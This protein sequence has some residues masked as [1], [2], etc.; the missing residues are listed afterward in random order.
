MVGDIRVLSP[1]YSAYDALD[2]DYNPASGQS[3]LVTHGGGAASWEDAGVT[4]LPNGAPYDNG[5]ILTNTTDV[6]PLRANPANSDGNFNPRV[7]AST[8]EKK[9]LMVTSSVFAATHGQFAATGAAGPV[10]GPVIANPVSRPLMSLDVPT[11][12]ATVQPSFAVSGWALDAGSPSGTGVDAVHVWAF[13]TSG[14]APIFLGAATLGFGRPDVGAYV[15]DGRF[16]P[17][18]FGLSAALSPGTYDVRA[19]AFSTVAGDVQQ[20]RDHPDH[21]H[22]AKLAAADVRRQPGAAPD[23]HPE[24]RHLRL[25]NRIRPQP[26]GPVS[27]RSTSGP[28][29]PRAARRSSWAPRA[30]ATCARTS[31]TTSARRASA[32]RASMSPARCPL[33]ITTWWC[34][35]SAR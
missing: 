12:N 9:W 30:S 7:A 8:N 24:H 34:S 17:S 6:R 21:G 26:P 1:F 23:H 29:R 2:I 5:F 10:V 14:A 18:G 22:P 33:A 16:T 27:R 4:I 13:P 20:H 35:P 11:A 15:G 25:G 28:T 32:R 3:L 31:P 19:Y